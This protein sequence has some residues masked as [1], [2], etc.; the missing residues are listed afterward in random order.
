MNQDIRPLFPATSFYTYLNSAA[1]SPMPVTAI[2]A[3]THQLN[4]VAAHGAAHYQDW[5]D[6]KNR[7][8]ALI[9]KMLCEIGRAHV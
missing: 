7:A 4:D 3:V 1:V 9:G 8:R 6:T 2:D 5:V